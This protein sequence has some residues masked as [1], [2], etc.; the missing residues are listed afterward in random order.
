MYTR[1]VLV[2]AWH[3][4]PASRRPR[5]VPPDGRA[6][7]SVRRAGTRASWRVTGRSRHTMMSSSMAV[8]P[9]ARTS[10]S[11][12]PPVRRRRLC[13][14]RHTTRPQTVRCSP[15]RSG[16]R[17]PGQCGRARRRSGRSPIRSV[18]RHYVPTLRR[19]PS[20]RLRRARP[21]L[22]YS[23]WTH[24][25]GYFGSRSSARPSAVS[26]T[27]RTSPWNSSP[28]PAY[29]CSTFDGIRSSSSLML[30]ISRSRLIPG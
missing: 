11:G 5:R 25:A 8:R 16:S 10:P 26:T 14:H 18:V 7:S 6:S 22:V 9:A 21:V 1:R 12:R 28:W 13:L 20:R 24:S 27:S 2:V 30:S 29:M 3:P 23:H 15:G 4:N 19:I 17:S